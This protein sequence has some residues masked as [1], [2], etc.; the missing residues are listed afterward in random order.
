MYMYMSIHLSQD[1][2]GKQEIIY[3]YRIFRKLPKMNL[4]L[5]VFFLL[6]FYSIGS[7]WMK[8]LS[9]V[10]CVSSCPLWVSVTGNEKT[11]EER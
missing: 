10:L 7:F 9:G 5:L 1:N 8:T 11:V 4:F 3:G 2:L 6:F